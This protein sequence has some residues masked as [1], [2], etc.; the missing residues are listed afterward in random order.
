MFYPSSQSRLMALLKK[1]I[2][3]RAVENG[4]IEVNSLDLRAGR[5]TSTEKPM[6]DHL[7]VVLGWF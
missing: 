2:L 3:G 1:S 7:A 4:I 5:R 6:I